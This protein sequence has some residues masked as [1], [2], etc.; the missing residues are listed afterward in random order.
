LVAKKKELSFILLCA[1][2]LLHLRL[3]DIHHD[4]EGDQVEEHGGEEPVLLVLQP[5]LLALAQA[6]QVAFTIIPIE[7]EPKLINKYFANFSGIFNA[8]FLKSQSAHGWQPNWG[9]TK[10][11]VD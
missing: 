4:H 10:S 1:Y 8:S 5:L 3:V 6:P 7:P 2:L 11:T 9:L